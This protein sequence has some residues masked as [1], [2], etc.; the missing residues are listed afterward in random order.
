MHANKPEMAKEWEA[1]TSTT[2]KLPD[3]SKPKTKKVKK[4]APP[5]RGHQQ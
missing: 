1:A 4:Y 3:R 5:K 2:T